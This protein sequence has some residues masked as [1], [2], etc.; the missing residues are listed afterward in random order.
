MGE[1]WKRFLDRMRM[2]R[3]VVPR[4]RVLMDEMDQYAIRAQQAAGMMKDVDQLLDQMS[5]EEKLLVFIL[6][7]AKSLEDKGIVIGSVPLT[8]KGLQVYQAL[9]D[10]GFDPPVEEMQACLVQH[11]KPAEKG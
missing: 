4:G 2:P 1:K 9:V 7:A 10:S 3:Y 6:G 5:H 11:F 8:G